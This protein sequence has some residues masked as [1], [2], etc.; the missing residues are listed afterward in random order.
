M[1]FHLAADN[2]LPLLLISAPSQSITSPFRSYR[3]WL[4]PECHRHSDI[5]ACGVFAICWRLDSSEFLVAVG[6]QD[7]AAKESN[8]TKV[9]Q[10]SNCRSWTLCA[11]NERNAEGIHHGQNEGKDS[12]H[13]K[14]CSR[15]GN[16]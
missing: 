14:R 1:H 10:I 7:K 8:P 12:F 2:H 13:D 5:F 16:L 11:R 6:K 9:V 3:Q 15:R 4:P